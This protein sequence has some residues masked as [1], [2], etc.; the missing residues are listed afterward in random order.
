MVTKD[1]YDFCGWATKANQRCSDG[2]TIMQDA[3]SGC[4]GKVVPMFWNHNHDDEESVLGHALLENRPEGVFM[5]G[6]FNNTKRGQIGKELVQHGDIKSLSIFANELKESMKNVVHGIIREVSL[7]P[8]GANPG[9]FIEDVAVHGESSENGYSAYITCGEDEFDLVLYHA[10]GGKCG[11]SSVDKKDTNDTKDS[12]EASD[13]KEEKQKRTVGDVIATLDEDQKKAVAI[14][15]EETIKN[16]E[17]KS[18]ENEDEGEKEMKHNL[19]ENENNTATLSH[20]LTVEE[21]KDFFNEARRLGSM[22][23]AA[24]SLGINDK[25]TYLAHGINDISELYP[26]PHNLNAP[27]AFIQDDQSWVNIVMRKI[28]SVP[29]S[30]IKSMFA[31][32]TVEEARAKGYVKGNQKIEEFFGVM[33]RTTQ[34][35]TVYKLQKLD[36]DDVI[37]VTEF[38]VVAWLKGEMNIKLDEEIARAILIGDGRLASSEGKIDEQCIRPVWTDADQFTTKRKITVPTKAT[39]AEIVAQVIDEAVRARKDYKGSGNPDFFT[40]TDFV[41]EALLLKDVNGRRIY[42]DEAALA[43][44]MRVRSIVEVPPMENQTRKNS[45]NETLELW[46]LIVN[47]SDYDKGNDKGGVPAMFDNFDLNFNKLEYL[48]ETR[49]CGA[50]VKPYSAVA[51][52]VLKKDVAA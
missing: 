2:R 7:V 44:A 21:T 37:D 29:F 47:L 8:A 27:P 49:M 3:F 11:T 16:S 4:D 23:A 17:E 19:F 25:I 46:G 14:L 40:T 9:A 36:R 22:K 15:L 20:G 6:L 38:D 33:K 30:K 28:H 1:N 10:D 32:I 41:T 51:L 13:N 52:E 26:E 12:K 24:Q 45:S 18:Q 42:E 43:K 5:Y 50:L 31:D 48:I 35:T 34:P 39:S